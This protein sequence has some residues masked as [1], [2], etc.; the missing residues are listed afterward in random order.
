MTL[1]VTEEQQSLHESLA[2]ML[3]KSCI[4][5]PEEMAGNDEGQ[6]QA[7]VGQ[8]DLA[9][10]LVPTEYGGSGASASVACH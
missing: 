7:L 8:M 4:S 2:A 6:R 1:L 10:L 9:G 3:A 5:T